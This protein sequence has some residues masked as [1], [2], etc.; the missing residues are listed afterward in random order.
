MKTD[1]TK[2]DNQPASRPFPRK[3]RPTPR[4][5]FRCPLC[6]GEATLTGRGDR[7]EF[8]CL[9]CTRFAPSR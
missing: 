2:A 7:R 6:G 8:A 5:S 3:A 4:P 1:T 9:D